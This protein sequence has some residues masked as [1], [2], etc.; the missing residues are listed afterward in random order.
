MEARTGPIP[1]ETVPEDCT[2]DLSDLYAAAGEW[3]S[4][5]DALASVA[6]GYAKYRGTLGQSAANIKAFLEFDMDLSRKLDVLSTYVQL[7]SDEDK[8]NNFHQGNYDKV[9]R[10]LTQVSEARSFFASEL[11]AI[12]QE[13]MNEFLQDLE[14]ECFRF[15]L[16]QI[17]RFRKH[18]LSEKEES[19]LAASEEIARA[20]RETFGM[21]DT[22]DLKLG[23]I[24]DESGQEIQITHGN[25]QSLLQH[26]N[27]GVRKAAAETFYAEYQDHQY[28]Y[29]SLLANSIKKDIFYARIRG[30]PSAREQALFSENIST[31]VYGNLVKTV[32]ENLPSLY[33]Y[34]SLRKKL[35]GIKELHFYDCSVPLVKDIHW[36]VSFSDATEKVLAALQP[37]GAE[38]ATILKKGLLSDRWV[39]RYE[40][41]GKRSGAYSSGCYDSRP[42]ILMNY[43]EDDINGIYTLAHEAGH[44]MHSYYARKS[45]PYPYSGYSIFVA[46]V[47]STFNETLLTRYL[48]GQN[49][50]SDMKI[51]LI[52]REIDNFRGTLYRQT[53]FAEFEHQT[54]ELAERGEPLTLETFKS[55]YKKL[56]ELYF[57]NEM[58]LDDFL[59][60]ECFRIPHF[61]SSFYVYKYATGISAA[62]SL[63]ERVVEGG[64]TELQEYTDFLHAGGAKYPLE[65][66]KDAGVDM[67]SPQPVSKALRKFSALVDQLELL[68][69]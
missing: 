68:T 7:K 63:A 64:E 52:C 24:K 19:L 16:E 47:A 55:I 62:Y 18:I 5:F 48:L 40:N 4:D 69:N 22:V 51:Y 17:L 46:E 35:L 8:T 50:G 11:M 29:A 27:R 2:W 13:R 61:Y 53:M 42:Y 57:G 31:E 45:Q 9:I 39:D 15:Y 59:L 1:R 43:R 49:I 54:H 10:L 23:S 20:S 12:P 66:L 32:H 44:S 14:L 60:L 38:Y 25:F 3:Q 41:K 21:L 65:L 67:A 6:A 34:F 28:T 58:K 56:L 36:H 33:K 30:Y 26:Y 37:L